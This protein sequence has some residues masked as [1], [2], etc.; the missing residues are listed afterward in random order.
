MNM[1]ID[2]EGLDWSSHFSN[3]RPG[4]LPPR[5]A[6][7][8]SVPAAYAL[9]EKY[10]P[11]PVLCTL[12]SR[13][14]GLICGHTVKTD[15]SVYCG[16]NC[17]NPAAVPAATSA[18]DSILVDQG[19]SGDLGDGGATDINSFLEAEL[20]S[21][22]PTEGL[23]RLQN[24]VSDSPISALICIGC[25]KEAVE[26]A[27][28]A[29]FQNVMGSIYTWPLSRQLETLKQNAV[30]RALWKGDLK[31]ANV[32]GCPLEESKDGTDASAN[33]GR[34]LPPKAMEIEIGPHQTQ[35]LQPD[36]MITELSMYTERLHL[37]ERN[38][39]GSQSPSNQ[40]SV[41][42]SQEARRRRSRKDGQPL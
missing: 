40:L 39:G 12:G 31:A 37:G 36:K 33:N 10:Y 23:D 18:P 32:D 6:P 17:I 25:I 21:P 24:L 3:Y 4:R 28:K 15:I 26:T 9:H 30:D 16:P 2:L 5:P 14:N 42:V 38:I 41:M 20:Y 34:R 11:N 7:P 1:A 19:D 13:L 22:G 27:F 29:K 8:H 35:V